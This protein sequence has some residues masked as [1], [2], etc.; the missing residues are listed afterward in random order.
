MPL[1][2]RQEAALKAV[3]AEEDAYNAKT[4]EL[5]TKSEGAHHS[6]YCCCLMAQIG[7]GVAGMRAKNELAQHLSEDPLPLRRAKISAESA[8]KRNERAIKSG[9]SNPPLAV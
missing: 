7:G 2:C 9:T 1:R 5:Q 8:V 3:K 4:Q 6:T